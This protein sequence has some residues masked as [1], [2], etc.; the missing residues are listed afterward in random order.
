LDDNLSHAAG[1]LAVACRLLIDEKQIF[2]LAV[3]GNK[4]LQQFSRKAAEASSICPTA[5]VY[6]NTHGVYFHFPALPPSPAK[7]PQNSP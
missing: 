6:S 2:V 4:R 3:T 1:Q 5:R 7:Y